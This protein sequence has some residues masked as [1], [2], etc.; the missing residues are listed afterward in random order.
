M[1]KMCIGEAE[2]SGHGVHARHEY[3]ER[4]VH[5]FNQ[6]EG[7]VVARLHQHAFEQFLHR[8]LFAFPQKHAR[9]GQARSITAHAGAF[10][11]FQFSGAQITEQ[12]IR[13]HEFGE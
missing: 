1:A 6:R 9:P 5:V 7:G 2:F 11:E 8:D 13:G 3:R 4:M 10:L 12:Q